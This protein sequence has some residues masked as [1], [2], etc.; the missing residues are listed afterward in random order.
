MFFR[1]TNENMA[2]YIESLQQPA[3]AGDPLNKKAY[4]YNLFPP[5]QGISFLDLR[6]K[7][8]TTL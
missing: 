6:M 4:G 8:I 5:R 7:K 1:H 3:L 2:F